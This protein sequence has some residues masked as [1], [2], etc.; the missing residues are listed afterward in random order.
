MRSGAAATR[1]NAPRA[2]RDAR[3]AR[4]EAAA[5]ALSAARRDAAEPFGAA[6][7]RELADLG[8]GEGEF[9]V[10]LRSREA[11]PSGTDEAVFL[12]RPNAGLRSRP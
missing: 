6:V 10:E 5:E 4:S 8:M 9:H 1:S 11:G 7:A 2:E 3:A 12:V